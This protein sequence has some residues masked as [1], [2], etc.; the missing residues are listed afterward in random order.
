[1]GRKPVRGHALFSA[2]AT[3][4][5][6]LGHPQGEGELDI[7]YKEKGGNKQIKAN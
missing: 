2:L 6:W 4:A 7:I 5:S 1:M 3:S